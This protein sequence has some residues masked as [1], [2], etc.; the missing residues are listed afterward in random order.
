MV[1]MLSEALQR[2]AKHEAGLSNISDCRFILAGE[3]KSEILRSAQ[4]DIATMLVA[5]QTFLVAA[6]C[7]P[8]APGLPKLVLWL[9]RMFH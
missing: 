7:I 2:N 6:T 5:E 1:V 9:T 8:F 4:N 3:S